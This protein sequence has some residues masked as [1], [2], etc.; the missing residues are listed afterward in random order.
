MEIEKHYAPAPAKRKALR[1][2]L[3][4]R[5][6]FDTKD[7]INIA[8]EDTR[9]P[10]QIFKSIIQMING[11]YPREEVD[12][13][14]QAC[15][16]DLSIPEISPT[17]VFRGIRFIKDLVKYYKKNWS[18]KLWKPEEIKKTLQDTGYTREEISAVLQ[19]DSKLQESSQ[20]QEPNIRLPRHHIYSIGRKTNIKWRIFSFPH[21]IKEN[22]HHYHTGK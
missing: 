3:P 16:Q 2:S 8:Q 15:Q 21:S 5:F 18:N 7:S 10:S 9:S 4:K 20:W 6:K 17:G 1:A 22:F 13:L 19:E 12:L 11:V 14:C